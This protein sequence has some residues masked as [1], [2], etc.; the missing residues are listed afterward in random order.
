MNSTGCPLIVL[1]IKPSIPCPKVT[2]DILAYVFIW[3]ATW[4][5]LVI[6][7]SN[8]SSV[9]NANVSCAHGSSCHFDEFSFSSRLDICLRMFKISTS[10][11][12]S[13]AFSVNSTLL[14][15]FPKA[16][17]SSS[18]WISKDFCFTFFSSS[19][20]WINSSQRAFRQSDNFSKQLSTS[21]TVWSAFKST[22]LLISEIPS[23]AF[24][25]DPACPFV[26]ERIST[27]L[28]LFFAKASFTKV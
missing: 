2:V 7:C 13:K 8:W 17:S 22:L 9:R 19:T 11:P 3:L 23:I 24:F 18:C 5:K 16:A 6:F 14:C 15:T 25:S 1:Y 4:P 27:T 20:S 26:F 28:F 10:L 21:W 12:F